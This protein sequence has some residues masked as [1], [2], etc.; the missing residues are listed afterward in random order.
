MRLQDTGRGGMLLDEKT[1][2][3]LALARQLQAAGVALPPAAPNAY[4]AG[5]L[6]LG[7]GNGNPVEFKPVQKLKDGV[8]SDPTGEGGSPFKTALAYLVTAYLEHVLAQNH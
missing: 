6:A 7:E 8:S 5:E 4:A 2:L 1:V 3:P